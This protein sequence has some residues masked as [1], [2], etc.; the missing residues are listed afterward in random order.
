MRSEMAHRTLPATVVAALAAFLVG[1]SGS[2][3]ST[4]TNNNGPMNDAT[5]LQVYPGQSI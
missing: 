1:C 5:V 3:S 4:G 2:T